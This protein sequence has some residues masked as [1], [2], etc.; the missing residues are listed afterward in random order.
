MTHPKVVELWEML[1]AKNGNT[2]AQLA[3]LD[4]WLE[5]TKSWSFGYKEFGETFKFFKDNASTAG[6]C[7]EK[8]SNHLGQCY[9]DAICE[10]SKW[11]Q[12]SAGVLSAIEKLS[13]TCKDKENFRRVLQAI[14]GP[15]NYCNVTSI[16]I[17]SGY[18]R[19]GDELDIDVCRKIVADYGDTARAKELE[20]EQAATDAEI[21][22]EMAQQSESWFEMVKS[23][24][25]R[26]IYIKFWKK[27]AELQQEGGLMLGSNDPMFSNAE[28]TFDFMKLSGSGVAPSFLA[29]ISF[30]KK[31]TE[32]K[33]ELRQAIVKAGILFYF[34]NSTA[35]GCI[36]IHAPTEISSEIVELPEGAGFAFTVKTKL[37][38]RFRSP[39]GCDWKL[40]GKTRA[41]AEALLEKLTKLAAGKEGGTV[42]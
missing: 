39:L 16:K 24:R 5:E 33:F 34:K 32:P 19:D 42:M 13:V 36:P 37:P 11:I 21:D 30:L 4:N 15:P 1:E 23:A 27:I 2:A 31:Y 14:A 40:G 25:A 20:A 12:N 9:C 6:A 17:C 35:K 18:F 29:G 41:D 26:P 8:F 7:A 38:R 3:A 10:A 22:R 28:A